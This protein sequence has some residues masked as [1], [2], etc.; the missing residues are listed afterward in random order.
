MLGVGEGIAEAHIDGDRDARTIKHG[1]SLEPDAAV[2]VVFANGRSRQLLNIE[3]QTIVAVDGHDVGED[4]AQ[5][6]LVQFAKAEEVCIA[7]GAMIIAGPDGHQHAALEHELIAVPRLYE[8]VDQ[9]LQ[10][11]VDQNKAKVPLL[12]ER[13]I[14]QPLPHGRGQIGDV[15]SHSAPGPRDR[16]A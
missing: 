13:E 4:F 1:D 5:A 11:I 16:G 2:D 8:A 15:L 6:V 7:R 3:H 10:P 12:F 14:A 9:P